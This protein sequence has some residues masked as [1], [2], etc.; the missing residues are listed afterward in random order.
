MIELA[1]G[2]FA[3]GLCTYLPEVKTLIVCDLHLGFEESLSKKGVLVP[4]FQFR[5]IVARLELILSQVPVRRVILN[6]D[7]KHE[8]GTVSRQEWREVRRLVDFFGKKG[9]G[10]VAVKGNHDTIFGP[11]AKEL[12]IREVPEFRHKDVLIVHGDEIPTRLAKV[13]VMGH[14]HP[15]VVIREGAKKEKFKCFVRTKFRSATVIVQPAFN[16]LTY[17]TDIAQGELLSPLLVNLRNADVFVVDEESLR[18]L[19]FGK[20]SLLVEGAG[21]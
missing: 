7:V 21:R 5:D 17:G 1:P 12:A 19:P 3:F 9:I 15:A 8:F 13:I 4:R 20:L 16:P 14:E 11:L 2:V 6:G 18:V 10:V